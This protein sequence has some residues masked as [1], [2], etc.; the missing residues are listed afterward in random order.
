MLPIASGKISALACS[1]IGMIEPLLSPVWVALAYGEM[2]GFFALIG[3]VILL[4][5]ITV[6]MIMDNRGPAA[7]DKSIRAESDREYHP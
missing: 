5:A 3:A 6:Y 2:P 1:L 4:G 7:Q